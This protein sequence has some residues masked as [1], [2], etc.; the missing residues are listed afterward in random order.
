MQDENCPWKRMERR[1]GPDI[2][3]RALSWLI[4]IGW[5][6]MLGSLILI[7]FAKPDAETFYDRFYE[8][9]RTFRDYWN[10]DLVFWGFYLLMT[11]IF[12]SI[13]GITINKKRHRRREDHYRISLIF[14]GLFSLIIFFVLLMVV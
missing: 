2:W 8:V 6:L 9:S 10:D 1:K 13:A 3:L 14:L 11:C 5:I 4:R 7:S 12:I